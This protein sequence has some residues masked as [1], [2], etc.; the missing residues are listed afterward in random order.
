M[1]KV[2]LRNIVARV[3]TAS[4]QIPII[5]QDRTHSTYGPPTRPNCPLERPPTRHWPS[6]QNNLTTPKGDRQ[7]SVDLTV[8]SKTKVAARG[9]LGLGGVGTIS[10]EINRDLRQVER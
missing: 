7:Q 4:P 10:A 3:V 5:V 2:A 9:Y 6:I 8:K 1:P